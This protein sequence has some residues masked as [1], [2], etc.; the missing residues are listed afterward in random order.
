MKHALALAVSSFA[1]ASCA[2]MG[3]LDWSVPAEKQ[4]EAAVKVTRHPN[5]K[6]TI[7]QVPDIAVQGS[8]NQIDW[9]LKRDLWQYVFWPAGG[10]I[11]FEP[12]TPVGDCYKQNENIYRCKEFGKDDKER[13]KYKYTIKLENKPID[14]LD[15]YVVNN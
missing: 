5:G 13:K 10:G 9:H 3:R 6:E 12:G 14:P 1:L 11:V 4:R 8:G 7:D 2:G 15:P